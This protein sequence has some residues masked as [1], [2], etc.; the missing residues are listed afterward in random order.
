MWKSLKS[1]RALGPTVVGVVALVAALV[2]GYVTVRD[3]TG[4]DV[5]T[6][7]AASVESTRAETTAPAHDSA[8][9]SGDTVPTRRL[10]SE[11]GRY[12]VAVPRGLDVERAGAVL[13]LTSAQKDLVVVVGPAGPGRLAQAENRL[14]NRMREEYRRFSVLGTEP[15]RVDGRSARA[16]FGHA[17]N[18]AGT[19]VRFALVTVHAGARN[20]SIAAYAAHDSDPTFVLPQVNAIANGFEVLGG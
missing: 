3:A 2:L 1:R 14:L 9:A 4:P 18:T 8:D 12:A 13:R 5:A 15:M 7:G 17:V 6:A 16:A 19:K 20:Y 11:P 10:V